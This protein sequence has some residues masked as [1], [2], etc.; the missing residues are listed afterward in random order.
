MSREI[1]IHKM[2]YEFKTKY[3]EGFIDSEIKKILKKFPN[4]N[5]DK[6]D[7]ALRG[8]TCMM[9]GGKMV[10][11]HCDIEKAIRCGVENRDLYYHEWD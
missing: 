3:E 11:Y 2:V 8:I 6:F 10:I 7:S 5:M 1:N 4:I 9:K